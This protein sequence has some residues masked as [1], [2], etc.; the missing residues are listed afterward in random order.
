MCLLAFIELYTL[1]TE[2]AALEG[3]VRKIQKISQFN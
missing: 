2:N 1:V 3:D